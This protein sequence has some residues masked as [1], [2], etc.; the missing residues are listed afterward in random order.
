MHPYHVWA[1]RIQI[2]IKCAIAKQIRL[3]HA[4]HVGGWCFILNHL[5][6]LTS[7]FALNITVNL[8]W[9]WWD[10]EHAVSGFV[11][12]SSRLW[13]YLQQ[14]WYLRCLYYIHLLSQVLLLQECGSWVT[15]YFP[16]W[17]CMIKINNLGN[18]SCW[19]SRSSIK[20]DIKKL[21]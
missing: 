20:V 9:Q 11:T 16:E 14:R 13:T 5:Q 2:V 19:R 7:P 21:G 3:I 12:P 15:L 4:V 1:H 18:L 8:C 10:C 17:M 6:L